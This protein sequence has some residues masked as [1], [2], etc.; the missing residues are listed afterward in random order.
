MAPSS[1]AVASRVINS[2]LIL[3]LAGLAVLV[4]LSGSPSLRARIGLIAEPPPPAY[5]VGQL[6]DVDP[7][8]YRATEY[9]LLVM[10]RSTCGA[11]QKSQPAYAEFVRL[12]A[13]VG[14][15]AR[16]ATTERERGPEEVFAS[17]MGIP[18]DAVS[19]VDATQLRV[20]RVPLLFLIDSTGVIRHLWPS[21]PDDAQTADVRQ[22]LQALAKGVE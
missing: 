8:L 11:C 22:A 15:P 18:A 6:I 7:S 12:A 4:A 20:T 5:E 10:A 1:D 16:L 13:S 3:C 21:I 14:I 9:T 17:S 2:V 19:F